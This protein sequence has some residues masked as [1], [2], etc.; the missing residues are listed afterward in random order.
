MVWSTGFTFL[1]FSV[2]A[3]PQP[4]AAMT[5]IADNSMCEKETLLSVVMRI[6]IVICRKVNMVS[7]I[8][9][10]F[11][12]TYTKRTLINKSNQPMKG[13]SK[14][15]LGFLAGVAAGAGLYAFLKSDE[16]K[17]FK[18]KMKNAAGDLKDELATLAKKG[19]QKM[20]EWEASNSS[21]K[22]D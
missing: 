3:E 17:A 21:S 11:F 7:L 13:S 14:A 12:V 19:K 8:P 15:L 2:A 5:T 16:G 18:E 4:T 10:I 1:F 20:E 22:Q 6:M 9:D